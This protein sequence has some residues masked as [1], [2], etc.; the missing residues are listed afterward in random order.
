MYLKYLNSEDKQTGSSKGSP[1][2]SG[3]DVAVQLSRGHD[4]VEGGKG[5]EGDDGQD[6]GGK[7]HCSSA[8]SVM[9]EIVNLFNLFYVAFY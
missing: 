9:Y 5:N 7:V 4:V 2:Q 1:L 3:L 8:I 6:A